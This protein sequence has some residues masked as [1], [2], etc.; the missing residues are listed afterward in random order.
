MSVVT[1]SSAFTRLPC[2]IHV[3]SIIL[4]FLPCLVTTVMSSAFSRLPG[5]IHVLSYFLPSLDTIVRSSASIALLCLINVW[6]TY[7]FSCL[8]TAV[9]SEFCFHHTFTS[10]SCHL[11][12]LVAKHGNS[13]EE[14]A[15]F[16][17]DIPCLVLSIYLLPSMGREYKSV[18][19]E[20]QNKSPTINL[21]SSYHKH[22]KWVSLWIQ[23]K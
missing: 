12:I 13:R 17:T 7:Y 9:V 2:L 19:A 20:F 23:K 22:N 15:L 18:N 5:L 6:F 16:S 21:G 10:D 11:H 14:R 4:W 8:A 3:L 1:T